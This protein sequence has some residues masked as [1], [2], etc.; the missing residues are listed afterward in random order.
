[1]STSTDV[2]RA[3]LRARPRSLL[4]PECPHAHR[5]PICPWCVPRTSSVTANL[6]AT[7]SGYRC[8][9]TFEPSTVRATSARALTPL[10]LP[11]G[12][13]QEREGE[14]TRADQSPASRDEGR[15]CC[16]T[17]GCSPAP[18]SR[19]TRRACAIVVHRARGTWFVTP[20]HKAPSRTSSSLLFTSLRFMS[21]PRSHIHHL[22]P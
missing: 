6:R 18:F 16:G 5:G 14:G 2:L 7:S 22:A 20:I 4:R 9:S 11:N 17:P 1:M 3:L 19:G 10:L 21:P 8:H 12:K 13:D 15:V